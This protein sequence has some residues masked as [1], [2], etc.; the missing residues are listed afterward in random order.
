MTGSDFSTTDIP[1]AGTGEEFDTR[2][3][4]SPIWDSWK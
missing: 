4:G 1:E 3:Q 2:Q